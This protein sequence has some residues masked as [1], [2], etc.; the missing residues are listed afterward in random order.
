MNGYYFSGIIVIV[1]LTL[2]LIIFLKIRKGLKSLTN[3]AEKDSFWPGLI[4]NIGRAIEQKRI[5]DALP[6]AQSLIE[7]KKEAICKTGLKTFYYLD[8]DEIE[9]LF[10][11]ISNGVSLSSVKSTKK[12]GKTSE[13]SASASNSIKLGIG[14]N[15][16]NEL[17][18]EFSISNKISAQYNEIENYFIEQG[19]LT[20]GVEEFDFDEQAFAN[21]KRDCGIM[22]STYNYV[23]RE[24]EQEEHW[25]KIKKEAAKEYLKTIISASGYIAIQSEIHVMKIENDTY[26]LNFKHPINNF[27]DI[28]QKISIEISC[29]KNYFTP[30]GQRTLVEGKSLQITQIGKVIRWDESTRTLEINPIAIY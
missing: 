28:D 20:F 30:F 21:F 3:E 1:I 26:F 29:N 5:A 10:P 7:R 2:I 11:Q 24:H 4:I 17:T 12:A 25:I 22:E 23:I 6:K 16:E 8:K 27:I 13:L 18:H 19:S 9:L 15:S 14:K